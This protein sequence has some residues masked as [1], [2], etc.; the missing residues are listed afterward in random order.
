MYF[1]IGKPNS[2]TFGASGYLGKTVKELTA[3]LD[4]IGKDEGNKFYSL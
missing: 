2:R 4:F 3:M 1:A